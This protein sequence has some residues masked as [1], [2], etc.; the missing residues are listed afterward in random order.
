L[1]SDGIAYLG[2]WMEK[3]KYKVKKIK[4]KIRFTRKPRF[5]REIPYLMTLILFTCTSLLESSRINYFLD[6]KKA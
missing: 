2:K 6:V 1:A 4:E 5:V 3:I